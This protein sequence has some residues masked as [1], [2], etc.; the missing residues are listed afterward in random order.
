MAAC[1]ISFSVGQSGNHAERVDAFKT[2]GSDATAFGPS[3]VDDRL[4][5]QPHVRKVAHA[6]DMSKEVGRYWE[7]NNAIRAA[8]SAIWEQLCEK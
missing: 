7:R 6:S 5:A 3:T 8:P 4:A 1:I 2:S